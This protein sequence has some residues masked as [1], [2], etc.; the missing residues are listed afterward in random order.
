MSNIK[1]L[2]FD[3]AFDKS[4]IYEHENM[5]IRIID[6][7]DLLEAKK[8]SGRFKDRDDIGQLSKKKK[9]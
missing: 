3:F 2:Q 4:K 5:N 7:E 9:Q 8:A 6:F 1:G